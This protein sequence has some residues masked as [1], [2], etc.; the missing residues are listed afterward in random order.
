MDKVRQL[1][2][3]TGSDLR[4]AKEVLAFEA[5]RI[6]HGKEMADNAR[7]TSQQLFG[8]K[9]SELLESGPSYAIPRTE[10]ESGIPAYVLFERTGL[11]K[12]KG[13]ARRL[14]SQGGGY[15][16]GQ[17]VERFDQTIDDKSLENNALLIRAGKKRYMKVVMS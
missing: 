7:Q 2:S 1:A 8:A 15:L 13:E 12:S 14:L 9:S 10:L 11:C 3:L 4:K 16:N 6:C 5:T 17:K